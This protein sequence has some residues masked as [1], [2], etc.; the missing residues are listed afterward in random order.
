VT[1]GIHAWIAGVGWH[2]VSLLARFSRTIAPEE[3]RELPLEAPGV[4]LRDD[5]ANCAY[6]SPPAEI[7]VLVGRI[8]QARIMTTHAAVRLRR[9]PPQGCRAER[10]PDRGTPVLH[11]VSSLIGLLRTP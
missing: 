4:E 9:Q 1:G 11:R 8:R 6:P 7:K 3:V 2:T 5:P 10:R